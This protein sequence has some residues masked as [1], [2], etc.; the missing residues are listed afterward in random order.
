MITNVILVIIFTL[1]ALNTTDRDSTRKTRLILEDE[2]GSYFMGNDQ[3]IVST[4]DTNL[5]KLLA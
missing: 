1:D 5:N 2:N 3:S 4:I